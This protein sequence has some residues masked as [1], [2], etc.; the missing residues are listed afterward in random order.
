[1]NKKFSTLVA[2]LLLSSAF[3][4]YAGNAKPMLATPT[5]V[6]T[7]AISADVEEAVEWTGVTLTKPA[8]VANR[9]FEGFTDNSLVVAVQQPGTSNFLQ[10][11]P[12]SNSFTYGPSP[13]T[14]TG[15][16]NPS[17]PYFYWSLR[18]GHLVNNA[19]QTFS[20]NSDND[21]IEIIPLLV[22]GET[23]P[24]FV[25]GQRDSNGDLQYVTGSSAGAPVASLT[26]ILTSA[27]VF[28]SVEADFSG[29]VKMNSLNDRLDD[30]FGFT[31]SSRVDETA[32]V[33]D[34]DVF[35]GELKAVN[36]L[37]WTYQLK[38]GNKYI[39]FDTNDKITSD[40]NAIPG[41]FK[42]VDDPNN[43][44]YLSKFI[45]AEAD[46]GSGDICVKMPGSSTTYRLYIA[47]TTGTY[48]LT[49]AD[50]WNQAGTIEAIDWAET[51]YSED[52][53]VSLKSLLTGQFYTVDFE[54][55]AQNPD[56]YKKDG[57]LAI[58]EMNN[59]DFVPATSLYE[60]APEAQW[61]I[62]AIKENGAT[63]KIIGI[64]LT[65]REN[66]SVTAEIKELRKVKGQSYYR[67]SQVGS[68]PGGLKVGDYITMTAV[69]SHTKTDGYRV[70]TTNELKNTTWYLGQI[71]KAEGD[72]E[73]NVYW[74][75][76]HAG[77]HQIGATVE[78][79]KAAKWNLSLVNKFAKD[80]EAET[81][82]ILV[83]SELQ[84][85][86][87]V[88]SRIDAKKDTLVILPY[89][90]QNRSNNEFVK[91][92]DQVNLD[93]YI[94]DETNKEDNRYAQRFALK[95]KAD[96]ETYN[97]VALESFK[98]SGMLPVYQPN[99]AVFTKDS[100]YAND[101]V[102]QHNSAD[103]G[104]WKNMD[105][106]AEDANSLMFV[107]PVDAPE[108][109]KLVAENGIDSVTIYRADND[110]Q[111]VYE[112]RDDKGSALL[113][114]SVSFL[115]IDNVAQFT[116]INPSL[117]VDTAY[118]NRGDNRRYQ[119]LLGVNVE[120]TT[121]YYCP[122]HG[123]VEGES[124]PCLHAER[125]RYKTGRYLI[126]MID[127][128]N[129]SAEELK[130]SIHNNPFIN[131]TE[132]GQDRAKLAFVDAIHVLT[133]SV[134][135]TKADKLYVINNEE[136]RTKYSV[137]DLS[138]SD[139]NVAKFAFKYVDSN[140]NEDFKIQT[141]WKE[142]APNT[143]EADRKT[144]E[145]GFLRW[146]NGCLVVENGYQAGDVFNMNEDETRTPT[147]NEEIATSSVVV[148]GTNGAV[149][150]KGAEGKNVIVSTILGKVVANEVVSSD[151][152][153]IAAPAGVVVVS[154]DGESF[155]VVVK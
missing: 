19:G 65:N 112:K 45:V 66:P 10:G 73:V 55:A 119:Y 125:V 135:M 38:N 152:A 129:I 94:C 48:A 62:S 106:Y 41:R 54:G 40:P 23:S 90:F 100:R 53:I 150:V 132:E 26:S 143:K 133:D 28:V 118:V 92:N 5:Q 42:L 144:S 4:V 99:G 2:S 35:A 155:K 70:L 61:A 86:N 126:N 25:L 14:T 11:L 12:S 97:Y 9:V 95:L 107:S 67:I 136:D 30:G 91:M 18:E 146:T 101:K 96:G 121:G 50:Y 114:R 27:T 102:Y 36:E 49:I 57:R 79:T 83:V 72:A 151:N 29:N 109:R 124:H 154:V 108:Y 31:I 59:A 123:F 141:L 68:N 8:N 76:N 77:S 87:P 115:N 81:D 13:A 137:I 78:E 6:E 145:E 148:A 116:E 153:T 3:S 58:R 140:V 122:E 105:M 138:T 16:A 84:E 51:T 139:F 147:A 43:S 104:T 1:M 85:W 82:S 110:K 128:A 15:V 80:H 21:F 22:A 33:A 71:R 88:K 89:A 127:T 120:E 20:V 34:A 113:K 149:V 56:A 64:K 63:G 37:G 69:E 7:R 98:K 32:T 75:E 131:E 111:V 117:Y 60:K 39:V 47:N 93:Y 103:Y 24:Y 142:Y 52:N 74:T 46:N 44:A 17:A 134:D 130:V